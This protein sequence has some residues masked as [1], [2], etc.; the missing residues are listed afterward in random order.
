[1]CLDPVAREQLLVAEAIRNLAKT[2]TALAAKDPRVAATVLAKLRSAERQLRNVQ[3]G[4]SRAVAWRVTKT[5]VREVVVLAVELAIRVAAT[6]C[7]PCTYL[8][9]YRTYATRFHHQTSTRCE[10]PL[11]RRPRA[12]RWNI[13]LVPFA[14][15]ARPSRAD[16]YRVEAF[17]GGDAGTVRCD[18]GGGPRGH[19]R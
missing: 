14:H 12:P 10:R 1:M 9:S 19:R 7:N 6:H 16:S 18:L 11:P 2:A 13:S 15:R 8:F 3:A 17:G 5:V 4:F